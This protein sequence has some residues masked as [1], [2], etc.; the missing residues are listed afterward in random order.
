MGT[1]TT[2]STD[3]FPIIAFIATIA[4]LVLAVVAIWLSLV[5]FKLSS[6]LSESTKEAAK[7]IGS[8]VERLEKLFD[9]L[10]AD[11]FSMMR[12]TVS[13][14]RKHI[15]PTETTGE[16]EVSVEIEK[17]TEERIVAFRSEMGKELSGLLS[18]QEMADGKLEAVKREMKGLIEKAISGSIEVD[19]EVRE[20]SIRRLI[21]RYIR[22]STRQNKDVTAGDIVSRLED[23]FPT[24]LIIRLLE[25]MANEGILEKD[26]DGIGPSTHFRIPPL[27]LKYRRHFPDEREEND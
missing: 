6:K 8:S 22:M 17:K 2:I 13:D 7:G 15:W 9:K 4:S 18:R 11:T 27:S 24:T 20:E 14:M 10:Y 5:F 25:S 1:G 16:A 19:R 12:D 26:S 21:M 3:V 23:Q